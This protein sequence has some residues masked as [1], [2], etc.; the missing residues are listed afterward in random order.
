MKTR[1]LFQ[2][3]LAALVLGYYAAAEACSVCIAGVAGERLMDAINWSVIFL[4]AMPYTILFSVLGFFVYTY[5]RAAK[6]ARAE[7]ARAEEASVL[8]PVSDLS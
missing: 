6:K 4:M 1:I 7:E 3:A 2:T 5:R 8:N